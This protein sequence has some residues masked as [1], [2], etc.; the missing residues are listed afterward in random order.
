MFLFE[1]HTMIRVYGLEEEHVLL[2]AF[3]TPRIYALEYII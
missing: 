2:L 1:D 3:L